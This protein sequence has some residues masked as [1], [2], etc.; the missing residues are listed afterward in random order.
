MKNTK[1]AK[2]QSNKVVEAVKIKQVLGNMKGG[3]KI[4]PEGKK[5]EEMDVDHNFMATHNPKTGDYFTKDKNGVISIIE[6]KEFETNY[7]AV[8]KSVKAPAK[9]EAK[10]TEQPPTE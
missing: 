8:E 2:F 5:A 1:L 4:I 10:S 6:G 7:T 3:A 9:E